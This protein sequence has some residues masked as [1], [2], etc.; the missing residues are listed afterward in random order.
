MTM[1]DVLATV[2]YVTDAQGEKTDVIVPL[3]TWKALLASWEQLIEK[4]E[5]QEDK[6]ILQDW[7]EKRAKGEL[8][9]ITLEDLEI[10]RIASS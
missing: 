4:L 6:D 7:L 10:E 2:K 3:V 5:D 1:Q 8:D 9:M